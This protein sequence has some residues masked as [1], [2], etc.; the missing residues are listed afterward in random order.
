VGGAKLFRRGMSEWEAEVVFPS[1]MN[2]SEG[3]SRAHASARPYPLARQIPAAG[4]SLLFRA[5][6][7]E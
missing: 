2:G 1:A 5:D 3:I 7:A 4:M 6:P